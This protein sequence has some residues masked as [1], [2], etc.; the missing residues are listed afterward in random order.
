MAI[1]IDFLKS[2]KGFQKLTK[3]IPEIQNQDYEGYTFFI[4]DT[5]YRSRLAKVTPK[6]QGYFVA[7]WEKDETNQNQAFTFENSP[8]Y[9]IIIIIDE[10]KKGFFLFPKE[11]LYKQKILKTE[12]QKGK[13]A[14][15]V[16]PSW[17]T[18][19]NPTAT[20][21]QKWQQIYFTDLSTD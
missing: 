21:T 10:T 1:S 19:L 11:I 14:I 16:Y 12:I 6:K 8:E 17:E 4:G 7:F 2:Q 13:M 9:L 5:T 15:R 3:L 18:N 20:K